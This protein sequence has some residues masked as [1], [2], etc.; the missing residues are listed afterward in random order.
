MDPEQYTGMRAAVNSSPRL[1]GSH[2]IQ[3]LTSAL[4]AETN[5]P[6]GPA[7]ADGEVH[8]D[9]GCNCKNSRCLKLYCECFAKNLMCGEHCNCRNCRNNGNFPTDKRMAVEAILE[10][11]PNAFQPKVKRKQGAGEDA[12]R[13][14]HNKGCNCRKSGCLK[15][16]CECYQMGVL[17]SELCKCVNCRNFE[18]SADIAN[19]QSGMFGRSTAHAPFD[20]SMSP[21][22]RKATLLAPAPFK[23]DSGLLPGKRGAQNSHMLREPPAKRVLFQKGP[24]LKSR[25]GNIGSPGGLHYETSEV[26]EDHPQNMLAA[27]TKALDSNIVTEAQKD[28]ALLLKLFADAAAEA[29]PAGARVPQLSAGPVNRTLFTNG[30]ESNDPQKEDSMSLLCDEEGLEDEDLNS[31]SDERPSWYAETEKRVLEQCARSLYVIASSQQ[32]STV[33]APGRRRK[34]GN[35]PQ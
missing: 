23:P 32:G 34:S 6:I 31:I 10:R 35:R 9:K 25:L 28:T 13:E 29:I 2:P 7:N 17:C 3:N 30:S 11:N 27:A 26:Y 14:K 22:S 24:A 20:R 19:A 8:F 33:A 21:A 1:T 16:Y 5:I 4:G 18:G 15:R 12:A